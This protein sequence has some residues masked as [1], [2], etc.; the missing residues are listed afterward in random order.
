MNINI[1]GGGLQYFHYTNIITVILNP[2]QAYFYPDYP[3]EIA[4]YRILLLGSIVLI[5]APLIYFEYR[6]RNKPPDFSAISS[7]TVLFLVSIFL[8]KC[9]VYFQDFF[10]IYG[11]ISYPV[12]RAY[13]WSIYVFL[14][15][16]ILLRETKLL[17]KHM[18]TW[19]SEIATSRFRRSK[20][21]IL[22]Y[23]IGIIVAIGPYNLRT[24][25]D[26]YYSEAILVSHSIGLAQ[27][28]QYTNLGSTFEQSIDFFTHTYLLDFN[29]E[30]TLFVSISF[31]IL[32]LRYFKGSAKRRAVIL[33]GIFDASIPFIASV[34]FPTYMSSFPIP[35]LL[36]AGLV[37]MRRIPVVKAKEYIWDEI[38]ARYWYE[39]PRKTGEEELVFVKVPI[40]YVFMSR[41][42]NL[43]SKA[44]TSSTEI[45]PKTAVIDEIYPD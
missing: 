4:N 44:S 24:F 17:E 27:V 5:T 36:L 12:E 20:Y 29:L 42:R 37:I 41:L 9:L 31:V 22:G 8:F 28:Y 15:F 1:V 39:T 10:N 23:I 43:G 35:F 19:N 18:N 11:W 34:I 30:I 16:P 21:T 38:P 7:A 33:T 2:S 6:M 3:Y 32:L 45:N 26:Y 40:R 14:V 13:T 25:G